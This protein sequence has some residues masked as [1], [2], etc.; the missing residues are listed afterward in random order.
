MKIYYFIVLLMGVN[1]ITGTAFSQS[2]NPPLANNVQ[3]DNRIS[4]KPFAEERMA[5]Q[6]FIDNINEARKELTMKQADLAQQKILAARNLLPIISRVTPAQR[7]LTRVEF[8]GGLYADDLT[9]RKSYAPIETQSLENLTRSTGPRWVKNTRAESDAKI[10]YIALDMTGGKVQTYL[11]EVVKDLAANNIKNAQI[12][13][14]ALSDQIIKVDDTVPAAVQAR[15]Y[16]TLADNYIRVSNFFGARNSLENANDFL[17]KMK[18]D[19]LYKPHRSDIIALHSNIDDLQAAFTK[20]DA[21]QIKNAET[22]LKK[23]GQQ[24]SGW[25]GE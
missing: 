23:W 5:A 22:N 10:I 12:H 3:D 6:N 14:A 15:D 21:D 18:D 16:I 25:T 2:P 17:N 13:L 20:L 1:F 24:L 8:G 9:Q 19:D 7:R 11:D 4:D